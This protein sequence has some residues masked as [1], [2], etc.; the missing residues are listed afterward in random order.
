MAQFEK[1]ELAALFDQFREDWREAGERVK[2]PDASMS[3]TR[4]QFQQLKGMLVL[5][6]GLTAGLRSRSAR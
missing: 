1:K 6:Y 5:L 4:R 2:D 3:L